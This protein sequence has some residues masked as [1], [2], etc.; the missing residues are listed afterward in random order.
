[1]HICT[2]EETWDGGQSYVLTEKGLEVPKIELIPDQPLLIRPYFH[3][4]L[5]LTCCTLIGPVLGPNSHGFF[6]GPTY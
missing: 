2:R 6:P 4:C 1:M 3:S 5:S